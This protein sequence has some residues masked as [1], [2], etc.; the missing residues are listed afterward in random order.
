MHIGKTTDLEKVRKYPHRF[1]WGRVVQVLDLG[2]YSFVEH[3]R[4]DGVSYAVYVDGKDTHTSA[5]TLDGAILIAIARKRLEAN[6]A[7]YMAMGAA[8]LLGVNEP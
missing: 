4:D 6:E 8:K 7:R 5:G 2:P 1:T 3:A